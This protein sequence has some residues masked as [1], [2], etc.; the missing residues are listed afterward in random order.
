M[1][2]L[3]RGGYARQ[4]VTSRHLAMP[5]PDSLTFT[6][7]AGVLVTGLTAIACVE[8][9]GRVNPGD[10]VLVQSAAGA[11]G[12]AVVQ[13]A[14]HHGAEVF[15]TAS[16]PAKL[17]VLRQL[18]VQHC[19]NYVDEDFAEAVSS[20]AGEVD[21]IVDALAG[22]AVTRG[23]AVLADG[24][25]FIEMGAGVALEVAGLDPQA[26]FLRNQTF[27]GVNIS[28]VMRRPAHLE[29]LM[30]RLSELLQTGALRPRVG[31]CLTFSQAA[32]AHALLRSRRSIGKVVLAA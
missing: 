9:A 4:V 29:R 28:Q 5:L 25:R 7:G 11:T 12:Q 27:S 15:G 20:R 19:I 8:E 23:M 22:D 16:S 24:G 17:D 1:A 13:L 32:D 21:V 30:R 10:R 6:E 3:E 14:L 2:L 18:G 26:M 31:H